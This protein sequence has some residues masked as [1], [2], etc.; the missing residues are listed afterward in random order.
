MLKLVN[1]ID[2][3]S[4]NVSLLQVGVPHR[5][6][7]V[8]VTE[9]FLDLIEIESVLDQSGGMRMA[10]SVSCAICQSSPVEGTTE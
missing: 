3:F 4:G 1:H 7:D 9:D 10:Q 5:G 2:G 8:G 6:H